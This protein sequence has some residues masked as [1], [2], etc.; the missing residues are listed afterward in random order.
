[1]VLAPVAFWRALLFSG[2]S[3]EFVAICLEILP[4]ILTRIDVCQ[5]K[6]TYVQLPRNRKTKML[7]LH[8]W[9]RKGCTECKGTGESNY[10]RRECRATGRVA[11]IK[12]S[13]W[14]LSTLFH[15]IS[16]T[17]W[18]VSPEG[19]ASAVRLQE[20]IRES[21]HAEMRCGSS[22]STSASIVR[23]ASCKTSINFP[24]SCLPK[25]IAA[26]DCQSSLGPIEM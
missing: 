20:L 7:T 5:I 18:T 6:P 12:R 23:L 14:Q 3:A 8:A 2:C 4:P 17:G 26:Q 24:T 22:A 25:V 13:Q 1:V 16:R 19:S 21:D 9:T 11:L 15:V 10:K